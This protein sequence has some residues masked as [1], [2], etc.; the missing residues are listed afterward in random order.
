M[1]INSGY[2]WWTVSNG[3]IDSFPPLRAD[4]R[5]EVAVIGAGITGGLIADVLA[6]AGLDVLLLDGREAGWGSTSA[7]T[8][9]LQYEIDAPLAWLADRY[10]L[11]AAAL[12]Y[13]ACDDAIERIAAV[14][15]RLPGEAGLSRCG[16]LYFA[17][18]RGHAAGMR[19]EFELRRRTGLPVELVEKGALAERFGLAAPLALWTAHAARLDPYRFTRLLLRDLQERG[20]RVYDR[21]PVESWNARAGGIVLRVEGGLRVHCRHLVVAAGYESQRWLDRRYAINHNSYALVTEPLDAPPLQLADNVVWETARPYVYLRATEDGRVLIGGEDDQIQPARRD[22]A[23]PRKAG[24][25]LRRLHRL[26]PGQSF[27]LGFAWGGT[28]A[29][30]ADGLPYIGTPPGHDPHVHF[31]MAYG[32]SGITYSMLAGAMIREA[33]LRHRHPLHELFGFG[34]AG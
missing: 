5:C 31:A 14:A 26:A 2:P 33:V 10:G 34:R 1:D 11:E 16:S 25:L 19:R 18:R 30:T 17:S 8:A 22:A 3:L 12:A 23:V 13:R 6:G 9:L 27:A 24:K 15:A 21:S 4:D 7:S 20:V 28:F 29:E 32:G